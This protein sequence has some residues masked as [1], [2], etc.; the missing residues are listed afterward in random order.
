MPA[1]CVLLVDTYRSLEGV[2]KAIEAARY[3][4]SRGRELNGIRLDSGDLAWLSVEARRLLDEAGFPKVA[5]L[6]SNELDG[7]IIQS[8]GDQG[9]AVGGWGVGTR[10]VTAGQG[11]GAGGQDRAARRP[12]GPALPRRGGLPGR[13]DLRRD[14][15]PAR[16]TGDGRPGRRDPA[17]PHPPGNAGRGPAAAGGSR[18]RGD[19]A[20]A[21]A[22]GGARAGP[23]PARAAARRPE[24]VRQPPSV[25]GGPRARPVRAAHAPGARGPRGPGVSHVPARAA[26]APLPRPPERRALVAPP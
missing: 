10:L 26:A 25:P 17:A 12:P 24:A 2:K 11:G 4:R 23:G 21:A 7:P 3:L 9:A 5:I 16:G 15:G 19:V 22:G 18:R 13:R 1:N 14:L 8:L 20:G 6:A